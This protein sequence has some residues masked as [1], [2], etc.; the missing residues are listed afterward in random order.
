MKTTTPPIDAFVLEA[1]AERLRVLA[2][3]HRLRIVELLMARKHTVGELAETM[4][5]KPSDVS[6][7]LSHMRAHGLLDV[8]R[9]GRTAYYRVVDANARNVIR[10]I[11]RHAD[12]LKP[13]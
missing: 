9:E 1:C 8:Q 6:R 4:D 10:C 2:H 7:H 12:D 13:N 5:L 3:A 11:R